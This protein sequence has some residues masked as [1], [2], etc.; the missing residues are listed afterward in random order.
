V[1]LFEGWPINRFHAYLD[2]SHD[3]VLTDIRNI[4]GLSFLRLGQPPKR[5]NLSNDMFQDRPSISEASRNSDGS[6]MLLGNIMVLR[7]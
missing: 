1:G 2:D 7:L 4:E 5:E 6:D 3:S